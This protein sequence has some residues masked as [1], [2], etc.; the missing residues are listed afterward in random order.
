MHGTAR[1]LIYGAGVYNLLFVAFHISFWKLPGLNW[2]QELQRLSPMNSA[3]MQVMNLALIALFLIMAF[4]SFR[5]NG[6]LTGT[7]LGRSILGG[8]T[9]LW[10]LRFIEQ[11]IFFGYRGPLPPVLFVGFLLY[12]IPAV[13][14]FMEA[15][16]SMD[17]AP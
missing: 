5:H 14:A 4:L 16:E 11:F 15:K 3:V 7:P 10:L 17:N 8:F 12:C 2:A 1:L 9:L 6:D 13:M